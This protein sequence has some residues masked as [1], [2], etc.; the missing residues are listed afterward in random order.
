MINRMMLFSWVAVAG[1]LAGCGDSHHE[2]HAGEKPHKHEH[3]PPHGGT[4]V[5]LGKE[6][7]HL[8]FVLEAT[9]GLM[10]LY[11]LD[12]HMENYVR[13]TNTTLAVSAQVGGQSQALSFI[14]AATPASGETV[15]DTSLFEARAEWLKTTTNF[16]ATIKVLTI[17]GARFENVTF[18]F[19][20]GNEPHAA[21]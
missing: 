21:P 18:N 6:Q 4:P 7:Y 15:G 5:V 16:D 19:P 11:V 12:G 3:T 10:Q 13:L 1:L 8:E 20:K 2:H 17:R 9:S 14:A